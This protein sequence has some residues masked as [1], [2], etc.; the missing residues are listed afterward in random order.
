M[1]LDEDGEYGPIVMNPDSRFMEWMKNTFEIVVLHEEIEQVLG[2]YWNVFFF[3]TFSLII[4]LWNS[5]F[6]N[7]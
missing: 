4:A 3:D 7:A 1:G 6:H 5:T 2:W